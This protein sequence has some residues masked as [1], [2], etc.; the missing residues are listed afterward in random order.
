MQ[1]LLFQ[2][3]TREHGF[4]CMTMKKLLVR[5]DVSVLLV[6]GDPEEDIPSLGNVFCL[7]WCKLFYLPR[8]CSW[9]KGCCDNVVSSRPS[10]PRIG[11]CFLFC[12]DK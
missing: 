3:K 5:V 9:S 8:L 11:A 4:D 7:S 1:L 12:N 10:G 6:L 2:H